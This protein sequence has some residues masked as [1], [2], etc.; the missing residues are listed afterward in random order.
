M[1]GVVDDFDLNVMLQA[2]GVQGGKADLNNDG[3]VNAADLDALLKV[4]GAPVV[5]KQ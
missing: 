2:Q 4:Y 5:A 1:N 3:V